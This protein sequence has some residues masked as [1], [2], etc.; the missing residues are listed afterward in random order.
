MKIV[1]LG[2]GYVGA[3]SAVVIAK[4]GHEAFVFDIN[5]ERIRAFNTFDREVI[6]SVLFEQDLGSLVV[7]NKDRLIFSDNYDEVKKRLSETDVVFICVPTPLRENEGSYDL[8]FF[9]EAVDKLSQAMKE[10]DGG[11]QKKYVVIVNKS[12]VSI[13]MAEAM[14]EKM[15]TAGVIN[16]GVVSNP[17]FLVEGQAIR[18]SFSP[19]RV[20]IGA[21]CEKD[22]TVMRELYQRFY[23][24][25]GVAYL[26]VNPREAAAGKLLANYILLS[27]LVSTLDVVGRVS[28]TFPGVAFEK[29][30]KIITADRRIGSYGF[31]NNIYVGGSCLTKDSA[32]LSFQLE[33]VGA[34][35]EQIKQTL[36]ANIFQRD[37]FYHRVEQAGFKVNDKIVAVFGLAFKRDTNDVRNS[38]AVDIALQLLEGGA[39]QL[40]VYDPAATAMFKNYFGKKYGEKIFYANNEREAL[41]HT[42]AAFILT[43][44]PQ[45]STL[46]QAIIK[47]CPP[48]YFI[49]DGRRM[50]AHAYKNLQ[51]KGYSILAVGSPFIKGNL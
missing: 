5:S 23:N 25:P 26:E 16:F 20:V 34:K 4:F 12:T 13:N 36:S 6:E 21:T 32:A 24:S 9:N 14:E 48:P 42:A 11:Q 41:E 44:W 8:S 47:T 17:E 27:R 49:A 46:D 15:T 18:D 3:C 40:R 51:E 28:E 10:R 7:Q 50:A 33:Q 45:F 22:F 19:D 43:D 2:A 30:R 37:N 38:G 35:A 39:R 29:I 1:Y 31:Y